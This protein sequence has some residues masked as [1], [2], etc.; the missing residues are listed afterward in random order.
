MPDRSTRI[1]SNSLLSLPAHWLIAATRQDDAVEVLHSRFG[2]VST[3]F[4]ASV[5]ARSTKKLFLVALDC[6]MVQTTA[7]LSLARLTVVKESGAV[8]L[9]AHV[10]PP[11]T[12]LDTNLRFSGVKVEDIE[13]ATF[14]VS[15]VREE[16]GKYI[17]EETVIVGHGLENDL[18][19]LRLVHLKVIDTAIVRPSF[20]PF[21]Q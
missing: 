6:E 15:S 2:F 8:V 18:K 14:D 7:G 5:Q 13:N 21:A 17:D 1:P 11:G 20:S 10:K 16:L 12:L 3:S 19:A 4:L 9:D